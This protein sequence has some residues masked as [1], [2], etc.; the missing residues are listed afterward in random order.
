MHEATNIGADDDGTH[1]H[2]VGAGRVGT[3]AAFYLR[4]AG[5]G[6]TIVRPGPAHRRQ[7][8]LVFDRAEGVRRHEFDLPVQP[9]AECPPVSRLIVACKTPYSAAAL[10]R[11]RL[12]DD[13]TVIRLQ[14][15]LGSLDGRLA[16]GQRLI[17][18][19]TTSAVMSAADGAVRVV[20]ENTTT[21]GGGPRPPWFDAL[22][23]GW[24]GL[25]WAED[26][27]PAQWRKLVVNA[28]LNPLTA[29]DDVANGALLERA[30]L[31]AEM[32]ALIDEAD[33][34][35]ARLDPNWPGNSHERVAAVVSATAANTSSMR[36]DIHAGAVTEIESINGWLLRQGTSLGMALPAHARVAERIRAMAA[37]A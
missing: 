7:I 3:L 35:L 20:A 29:I 18:G 30:D 36:A 19:V 15:G 8:R 25:A 4:R 12:T 21:F 34:L 5:I 16:A 6:I 14:N 1:W 13:A 37:N 2:L 11:V 24:P 32:T 23:A 33:A 26:V 27:R 22:A 31:Y 17:E 28:A 10:G 9:P